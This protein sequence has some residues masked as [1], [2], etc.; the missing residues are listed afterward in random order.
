MADGRVVISTELDNREISRGV[1]EIRDEMRDVERAVDRTA[2]AVEDYG[3]EFDDA[4][5]EAARAAQDVEN[6]MDGLGDSISG[7][8]DAIKTAFT[9]DFILDAAGQ[10]M[11][12][13]DELSGNLSILSTNAEQAGIGVDAA[14]NA[15]KQLSIVSGDAD[16]ALEAISNIL[17]THVPEGGLEWAVEGLANAVTAF[18]DT[19]SIESLADGLQETLATGEAAG[20]FAEVLDRIG[21]GAEN[22][23]AKMAEMTTEADKQAYALQTLTKGPLA[24]VY[25]AY[26]D[27]NGETIRANDASMDL[28]LSLVELANQLEP[29]IA[30]ITEFGAKVAGWA[31]N[32]VD[33]KQLFE[34]IVSGILALGTV[35]AISVIDGFSSML[36]GLSSAAQIARVQ[37][38]LASIAFAALFYA[39]MELAKSWDNMTGAEKVISVLGLVTAAALTAAVAVGAF[40]SALTLGIAAAAIT[41][42]IAAILLAVNSAQSRVQQYQS[43]NNV[44][45]LA[46]GA[47]GFSV[48]QL[49]TGAVIPANK[50]FL[51]QLGD[52]KNGYNLEGPESMFRQ[53][54][55]E[56]SGGGGSMRLNV[57][58]GPGLVRYLKFELERETQ[59]QG[60]TL[61][62]GVRR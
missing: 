31:A 51:A 23:N 22:F 21:I 18:P 29:L 49:A 60:P 36:V 56:E 30:D 14:T 52:Q 44:P 6:E 42:G 28:Q 39:I 46:G 34:I 45:T 32:N 13:T 11:D 59:R 54:V 19:L 61:I 33:L 4:A 2:D 12:V 40:Q 62:P 53:I 17:Q 7:I 27:A 10:L 9:V 43:I 20:Q 38:G 16:T 3:E 5:R 1:R 58:A 25:Q 24:G 41:A 57:S 37:T 47:S 26:V 48:P 35:K 15:F 55:R 50:P 8:G